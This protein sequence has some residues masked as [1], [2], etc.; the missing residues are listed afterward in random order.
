MFIGNIFVNI[1]QSL[2]LKYQFYFLLSLIKSIEIGLN[3]LSKCKIP[4]F[5]IIILIYFILTAYKKPNFLLNF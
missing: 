2:L 4:Y 1:S 5:E 3:Y